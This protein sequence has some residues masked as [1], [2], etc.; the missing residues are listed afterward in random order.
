MLRKLKFWLRNIV[1]ISRTETN[2]A[3]GLIFFMVLLLIL[4]IVIPRFFHKGYESFNTDKSILD[5]I[6]AQIEKGEKFLPPEAQQSAPLE[7]IPAK[8]NPN[9]ATA[10]E[11]LSLGISPV[12]SKRIINFREKGGKFYVKNDLLKIYDFPRETFERL[13]AYI[14]LP[15]TREQQKLKPSPI[16]PE[17]KATVL[18][19]I[20]INE[21]DTNQLKQ[22]RGIG[23]VLSNRI[24]N[25]RNSLGGF[26]SID[27]LQE[28]YGLQDEALQNLLDLAT[29][30]GNFI[31]RKIKINEIAAKELASHPYVN[32]QLARRLVDYRIQHGPFS[33]AEDMLNIREI[34]KEDLNKIFPYLEFD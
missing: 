30:S 18:E 25:Y 20:N 10:D 23:S 29:V 19:K 28:V 2:G 8:F 33:A 3:I 5:S 27:Q 6:I 24:I 11:L 15:E 31:P 13:Y 34:D 16:K 14:D 7:N 26:I 17:K 22:I 4:N 9:T 21:A 12:I 32:F 1:G